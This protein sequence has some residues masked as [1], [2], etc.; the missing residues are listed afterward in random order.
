MIVGWRGTVVG[1]QIA[2]SFFAHVC[3]PFPISHHLQNVSSRVKLLRI[4]RQQQAENKIKHGA[5]LSMGPV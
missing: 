3:A 2:C 4:S 5:L 1:M